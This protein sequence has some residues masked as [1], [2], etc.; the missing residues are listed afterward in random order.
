MR[1]KLAELLHKLADWLYTPNV[2]YDLRD[3]DL[4]ELTRAKALTVEAEKLVDTSGEY[5]RHV[6]YARLIK[7]F[8]DAS[9]RFL[10]MQ[11]EKALE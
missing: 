7:E 4:P 9:K 8:P 3:F 2:V 5:K 11:I 10:S 1:K 6:V